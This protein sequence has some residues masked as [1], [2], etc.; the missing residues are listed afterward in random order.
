MRVVSS[1]NQALA[2]LE[3]CFEDNFEKFI[4]IV[5]K[6]ILRLS[7]R[8]CGGN[9]AEDAM[10]ETLLAAYKHLPKARFENDKAL[11][12]WLFQ[13][14]KNN[15]LRR[16][17]QS[18]YAPGRFI[19]IDSGLKNEESN[20][21][22]NFEITDDSIRPDRE[23]LRRELNSAISQAVATLPEEQQKVFV[24]R[25]IEGRSTRETAEILSISQQNVKVRLHRAKKALQNQLRNF[26]LQDI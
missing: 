11:R 12:G 17:R 8:F 1:D 4:E 3:S 16:K 10:Q 19:S 15:C 24:M 25:E 14:V 21:C 7:R 2:L 13:V 26:Y 9:D 20:T 23:I 18:K 22:K 6:Q 5:G